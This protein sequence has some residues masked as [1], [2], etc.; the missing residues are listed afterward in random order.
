MLE[1]LSSR[2]DGGQYFAVNQVAGISDLIP[3]RSKTTLVPGEPVELWDTYVLLTVLAVLLSL[4]W[5][6]RKRFKLA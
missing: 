1:E 6:I 2:S 4:E 3:D 5:I